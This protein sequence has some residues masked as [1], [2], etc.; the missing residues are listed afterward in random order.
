[1]KTK[2]NLFGPG[3]KNELATWLVYSRH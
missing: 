2:G 1:L 3:L